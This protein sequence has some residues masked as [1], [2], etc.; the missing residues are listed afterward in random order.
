[1]SLILTLLILGLILIAPARRILRRTGLPSWWAVLV[2]LP[3]GPIIFIWL[4]AFRDWSE[5]KHA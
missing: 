5:N 1:M 3:C 2:F 4:V